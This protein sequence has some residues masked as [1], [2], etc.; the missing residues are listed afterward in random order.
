MINEQY[1][2]IKKVVSELKLAPKLIMTDDE[3]AEASLMLRQLLKEDGNEQNKEVTISN[4]L[5]AYIENYNYEE[6]QQTDQTY[7]WTHKYC[8]DVLIG[9]IVAN[10]WIKLAAVRHFN[11]LQKSKTDNF[12]YKFSP[13]RAQHAI[14]FFKLTTHTKGPLGGTPIKL[15]P[16]QLFIVGS[17]FGWVTKEKD[18]VINR[19]LRR[20]KRAEVFV[21]RKN[22]KS[23]LASGIALYMLAL[24]SENG[25]EVYTAA[26][27]Q[28]Q[29]RI[30]FN[31]AATMVRSGALKEILQAFKYDIRS[32]YNNGVFKALAA[33]AKN[34]DGKNPHCA[35]ID[36]LHTHRDSSVLDVLTSGLG[37]RKQ[38][39][40]FI[41]STA[42][43]VLDGVATDQ[44]KYGENIL[45]GI[46][47]DDEYF[48]ALYCIDDGDDF[49]NKDVWIKSNPCIGVSMSYEYLEAELKQALVINS[50]K[51]NFL[52]KFCNKFVNS[53]DSWLDFDKVTLCSHE[54]NLN[55]Y[56][57]KQC[58][59]GLD[60]GQK[61]DL[62]AISL[63]FPNE[64]GGV[65]V[66]SKAFI[67]EEAIDQ[68]TK[69]QQMLYR[70]WHLKGDLVVTDGAVTDFEMIEE[71]I[72]LYCQQFKVEFV[73]YDP[74][75]ATQL[76][77]NLTDQNIPMLE[78]QQTSM[79]LSE[80]A[81]EFE[82]M[83]LAKQLR[84]DGNEV[85]MWCCMNS[86]VKADMNGNIKIHKENQKS[87]NKIDCVIAC[88]TALSAAVYGKE[89][90]QSVYETRGIL[91]LGSD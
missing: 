84:H 23:T 42:G 14:D 5:R 6:L 49:T 34:L 18:E 76:A 78:V 74:W 1:N 33:E 16:W 21:G 4:E 26:A 8:Y 20:Y 60:L 69:Q 28:D 9:N 57:G 29:A 32:E 12:K 63:V 17:I 37:A 53:S 55:E 67:P 72:K 30:V 62:T 61:V 54:L 86:Y 90:E 51:A 7:L 64:I 66:F 45:L 22:G 87:T 36:E 47:D 13:A 58:Y 88:I 46:H 44:W 75:S 11:D 27:S 15:M 79:K 77:M 10:K 80:P 25:P 91:V 65:D 85:F 39:L 48:A 81:K 31:D 73:C 19:C 40:I 89:Q 82:K 2:E 41:I 71:Y 70:K 24:D 68:A 38:P 59:L 52:T 56:N 50:S 35:I 83:I 3:K 43:F